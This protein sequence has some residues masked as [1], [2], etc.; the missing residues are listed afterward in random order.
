MTPRQFALALDRLNLKARSA[1]VA[2]RVLVDGLTKS[3][4]ARESGITPEAVRQAVRRV[5]LAHQN[6]VGCPPGW[7]CITVCVP[8]NSRERAAVIDAEEDAWRAAGLLI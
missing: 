2:R 3:Q 5:E 6:I 1:H 4:A 7:E 8:P